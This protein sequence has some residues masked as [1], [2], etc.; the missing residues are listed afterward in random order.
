MAEIVHPSHYNWIPGIEC[1]DVVKHFDFALGSVIKYVWRAG[2][3][4]S[5]TTIDDLE[6]AKYYIQI[7][8][9]RLKEEKMQELRDKLPTE[10]LDALK[11]LK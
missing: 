2:R 11:E 3:K 1:M 7:E 6:K 4:D 8:I 9:D 5:E 10:Y